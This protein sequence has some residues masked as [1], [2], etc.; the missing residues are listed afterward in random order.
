RAVEL[1]VGSAAGIAKPS[2]RL[3]VVPALL[4]A[5][6]PYFLSTKIMPLGGYGLIGLAGAWI[7]CAL[8]RDNLASQVL[9]LRPLP[10][11]GEI[12]Y[13]VYLW[14]YPV[15]RLTDAYG[16]H[17][18]LRDGLVLAITFGAAALSYH[19]V[20]GPIRRAVNDRLEKR[21]A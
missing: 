14:H 6:S 1:L 7:V 5:F 17:H 19:F 10:Y 21:P 3:W 2:G 12:S 13:G 4:I 20:E 9:S 18:L 11:I 8:T 15:L 16:V